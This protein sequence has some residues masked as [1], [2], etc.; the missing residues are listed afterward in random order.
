MLPRKVRSAL[1]R[2]GRTVV[3]ALALTFGGLSLWQAWDIGTHLREQARANS[4]M[5]GEIIS[6]LNDPGAEAA[7]MFELA[8]QIT[9]AGIPLVLTDSTGRPLFSANL[10]FR[11]GGFHRRITRALVPKSQATVRCLIALRSSISSLAVIVCLSRFHAD[12]TAVI[13]TN[14]YWNSGRNYSRNRHALAEGPV[15]TC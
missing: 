11:P 14:F 7:A 5:Y 10:P 2:H 6:S 13:R 3:L 12:R 1:R 9:E 8:K 15:G 4:R